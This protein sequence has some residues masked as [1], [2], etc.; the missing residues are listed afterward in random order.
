MDL[1]GRLYASF[2][3][4]ER[5]PLFAALD[6]QVEWRGAQDSEPHRGH[7]GVRRSI[8]AWFESLDGP[9]SSPRSSRTPGTT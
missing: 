9:P 5:E 7:E 4:G 1:V 2:N 3:R 6:E 8:A